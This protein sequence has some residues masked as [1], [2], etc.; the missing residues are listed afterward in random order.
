LVEP[1][2]VLFSELPYC[3]SGEKNHSLKIGLPKASCK[4]NYPLLHNPIGD[5]WQLHDPD[6]HSYKRNK[7]YA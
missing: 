6:E 3:L 7:V 5:I 2:N 1:K 4:G